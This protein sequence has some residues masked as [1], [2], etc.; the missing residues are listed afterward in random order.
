MTMRRRVID[1]F[2]RGHLRIDTLPKPVPNPN[3]VLVKES[4]VSLNYRDKL[5][6]ESGLGTPL[7]FPFVPT[8][9]MAGYVEAVGSGVT[10]FQPGDR[11]IANLNPD[12][13]EGKK[14]GTARRPNSQG[15][16]GSYQGMLSEYVSLPEDW[17]VAAPENLNNEEA[18]TLPCAGLTAWFAFI[19]TR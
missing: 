4:A 3:E 8:S 13:L 5:M 6:I 16:G 10:R 11:V 18:S 1:D 2:G 7:Q 9:D 15:L 14:G 19:E 17:R 12:W